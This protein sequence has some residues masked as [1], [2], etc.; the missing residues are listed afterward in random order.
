MNT[1]FPRWLGWSC[2]IVVATVVI[3]TGAFGLPP[4]VGEPEV[5]DETCLACHDQFDVSL[6]KSACQTGNLTT[7]P[8]V[9]ISCVYCHEGGEVHADDPSRD[10]IF[11]PAGD[12]AHKTTE[13][14]SEC[15][16][17][18]QKQESVGFDPMLGKGFTCTSCHGVH[19]D[20]TPRKQ[21]EFC[22]Q[23][24]I[25]MKHEYSR[26]SNH[27][28]AGGSIECL[29]C[30]ELTGPATPT[31][32]HGG[33]LTCYK[34]HP[35]RSGPFLYEHE[36]TSSFTPEGGAGCTACHKAHGSVNDR[37]LRQSTSSLCRQCHGS[38]PLH[39][40]THNGIG[41][42]YDCIECHSEIHG[43]NHNSH[44]LDPQLGSKLGS[45]PDGCYCH[46]VF[47]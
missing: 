8:D 23:C 40:V 15:H 30:H 19:K 13:L 18:H 38:P 36:A 14:C 46:N 47:E 22:G 4:E 26:N 3:T 45:G 42:A 16:H 35:E 37:L 2:L 6:A 11:N 44:L 27:P 20:V 29:D 1:K 34:C 5:D 25:A 17:P 39:Q 9:N 31:F 43:S 33:T 41:A 12:D 7:M 32:G 28:I 21:E 24:H 10:N